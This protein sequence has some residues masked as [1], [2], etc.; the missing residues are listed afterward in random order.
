MP[1]T[2]DV[3]AAADFLSQSRS[4]FLREAGHWLMTLDDPADVLILLSGDVGQHL[5]PWDCFRHCAL[6]GLHHSEAVKSLAL[7]VLSELPEPGKGPPVAPAFAVAWAHDRFPDEEA[8][9]AQ[10]MLEM[11]R[12]TVDDERVPK[13]LNHAAQLALVGPRG[14]FPHDLIAGLTEDI[15]DM[16]FM[17]D[18]EAAKA[19]ALPVWE[20]AVLSGAPAVDLPREITCSGQ[21]ADGGLTALSDNVLLRGFATLRGLALE[22]RALA[23]ATTS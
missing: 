4:R 23:D 11:L 18:G 1:D 7:D 10:A 12:E 13:V 9:H 14:A 3:D 22:R 8:P 2:L 6:L 17:Q 19:L 16:T 20:A 15:I 5:G 21:Q